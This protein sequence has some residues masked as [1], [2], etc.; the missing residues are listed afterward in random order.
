MYIITALAWFLRTS[1]VFQ[2]SCC[3]I[4]VGLPLLLDERPDW[5][6]GLLQSF[7][8]DRAARLWT[9]SIWLMLL[10]VCGPQT[11]EAYSSWGRTKEVYAVV[12]CYSVL[13]LLTVYFIIYLCTSEIFHHV[14][15]SLRTTICFISV[16]NFSHVVIIFFSSFGNLC[17]IF[18]FVLGQ[19]WDFWK[20]RVAAVL[21]MFTVYCVFFLAVL[22]VNKNV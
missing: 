4:R 5:Q 17:S 3:I 21:F 19:S 13:Q 9:A 7:I 14:N 16:W 22:K 6:C 20:G 11:V 10:A 12:G 1:N 15:H 2:P 18:G 8:T